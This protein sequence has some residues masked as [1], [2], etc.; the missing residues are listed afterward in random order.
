MSSCSASSFTPVRC[1]TK[2]MSF[3]LLS[4]WAFQRASLAFFEP[5]QA[6]PRSSMRGSTQVGRWMALVMPMISQRPAMSFHILF[7]VTRC[8]SATA[9][10]I[11]ERR[12]A[13]TV[14]LKGLP[15]RCLSW[16]LL[17]P[18]LAPM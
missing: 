17:R 6:A 5:S 7:D 13:P 18:R 10:A 14:M 11:R 9:L 1:S 3:F 15:P 16:A 8:R 4:R 12:R 2:A